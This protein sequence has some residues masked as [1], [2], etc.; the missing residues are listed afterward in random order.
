[1]E[2]Q[3]SFGGALELIKWEI[4][5]RN[6]NKSYPLMNLEEKAEYQKLLRVR[7]LFECIR[8]ARFIDGKTYECD[9]HSILCRVD[10][11]LRAEI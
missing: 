2:P 1:M 11:V 3:R 4:M 5:I 6:Q 8:D 7:D 9:T 10:D